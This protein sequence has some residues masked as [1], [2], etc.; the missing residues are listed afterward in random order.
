[1]D[2]GDDNNNDADEKRYGVKTKPKVV[3]VYSSSF[4]NIYVF[5]S[6]VAREY[7]L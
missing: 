2:R 7:F 5:G 4:P 1:M 6:V 3:G